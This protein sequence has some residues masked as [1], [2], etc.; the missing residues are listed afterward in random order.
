M[1]ALRPPGG[2]EPQRRRRGEWR[3][4]GRCGVDL[5][6][7]GPGAARPR[8]GE[9]AAGLGLREEGA[10]GRASLGAS[11]SEAGGGRAVPAPGLCAEAGGSAAPLRPPRS[12]SWVA[13][14]PVLGPRCPGPGY[15][16]VPLQV[17]ESPD[18]RAG[19]AEPGHTPS[20][21][22]GAEPPKP[23]AEAAAREPAPAVRV[24]CCGAARSPGRPPAWDLERLA[25]GRAR[26]GVRGRG[27]GRRSGCCTARS[28]RT[29]KGE[30]PDG[31][32]QTLAKPGYLSANVRNSIA[33]SD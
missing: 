26:D 25:S 7:A 11:L 5:L 19:T 23:A 8:H 9:G 4:L 17:S 6:A 13:E 3:R 15:A 1:G 31:S 22:P 14:A 28:G 18:R 10:G 12:P 32:D 27:R 33:V 20:P 24:T 29:G 2:A 30:I 16:S 21:G